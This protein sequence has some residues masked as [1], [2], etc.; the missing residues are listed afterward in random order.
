[1][2]ETIAEAR[3]LPE[4]DV[5]KLI[6]DAPFTAKQA[7]AAKLVD[8]LAYAED[9][10]A[11]LKQ[12]YGENVTFDH[13]YGKKHGPELD[14][15]SI[16]TF[17]KTFGEL[18][19]KARGAEKT[20][21][22]VVYVDG[23]I[24]TGK[25]EESIFG[26]SGVAASTTLRRT[27]AKAREDDNIKAVVL[28]VDSPGG[29]A[30]ASEI[31]WHAAEE[32]KGEKPF[33]VSM[34]NVAASGGYYVSAGAGTIFAQPGTI[35]GS[36]GVV[37][38]K[39]ITKGLWDWIG[40]TWDQ[41]KAGQNADLFS[42]DRR[43]DERQRAIIRRMMQQVYD[44]FKNRV[45]QGRGKKLKKD[46]EQLAGGR[47]YTGRQ[48]RD[49]G[50]VDKIGGLHDAVQFAAAEAN[51]SDYEVK[52][53]PEPRNFFDALVESLTGQKKDQDTPQII[54]GA[55][56][57]TAG[58]TSQAPGLRDLLPLVRKADPSRF[59]QIIRALLRIELLGG[60]GVLLVTPAE[61]DVR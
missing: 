8:E 20:S 15:S 13:D 36:I 55:P 11:S 32:L 57:G 22:G 56:K 44:E 34:G 47:V 59:Q 14:F 37:G 6:D 58:W 4:S 1:M 17:F 54:L 19:N 21:I 25:E 31:I 9:F 45:I 46:M 51:L 40:I 53:M 38:G 43:F 60:E 33:V 28:R 12:R 48:A 30:L 61:I 27:I 7:L 18:M 2:V 23:M 5:R 10:T 52:Q 3:Q 16:F 41:T 29:S 35:T 24:V 50:L 49:H 26:D 42:T 39:L